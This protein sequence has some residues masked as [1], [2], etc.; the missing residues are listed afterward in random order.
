MLHTKFRENLTA[1]SGDFSR[2]FTM[3]GLGVAAP[4]HPIEAPH[5]IWLW[6]GKRFWRRCLKLLMPMDAG[7]WVYYKLTYEPSAQVS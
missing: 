4:P 1:G 2:V 5:K 3:Y 6:S 7:A